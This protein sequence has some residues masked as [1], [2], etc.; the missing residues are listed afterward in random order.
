M[1]ARHPSVNI[2]ATDGFGNTPLLRYCERFDCLTGEPHLDVVETLLECGADPNIDCLETVRS[3]QIRS[4]RLE[5]L[6]ALLESREY[7]ETNE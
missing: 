3:W 5:E 1:L 7:A 6:I 2:N 4:A